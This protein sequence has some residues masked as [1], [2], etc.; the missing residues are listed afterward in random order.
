MP[1]L[2]VD[3]QHHRRVLNGPIGRELLDGLRR[4]RLQGLAFYSC[5]FRNM[6]HTAGHAIRGP[7]DLQGLKIRVMESPVML[8]SINAMGA[9]ATPLAAAEVFQA[10][11]TGVVDGAENNPRVFVSERF[12]EAGCRNFTWTR[13]FANQHVLVVN[14]AWFDRLGETH[15][16]LHQ[17]VRD[18]ATDIIAGEDLVYETETLPRFDKAWAASVAEALTVM[19]DQQVE[20]N[21]VDDVGAFVNR[22]RPVYDTFFRRHPEIP[23]ALLQRIRKEAE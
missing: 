11:K 18:V 5:G 4:H 14:K 13:H 23:P 3:E 15:P 22:V 21:E 8:D 20:I 2:F 1:Y 17:L 6:F 12:F 19:R 9:S 7:E 10:L 16:D